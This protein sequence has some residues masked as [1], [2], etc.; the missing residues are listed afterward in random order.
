MLN[1]KLL[2]VIISLLASIVSYLGYAQHRE[3]QKQAQQQAKRAQRQIESRR[4]FSQLGSKEQKK[5][6]DGK[7][8]AKK[9]QEYRVP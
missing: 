5:S 2:L 1:T 6:L 4:V 8:V 3:A 7:G 9:L